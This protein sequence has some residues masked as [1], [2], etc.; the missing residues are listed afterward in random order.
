MQHRVEKT[1]ADGPSSASRLGARRR[2]GRGSKVTVPLPLASGQAV[3][4]RGPRPRELLIELRAPAHRVLW[5]QP[6]EPPLPRVDLSRV[7][8]ALEGDR[9][10]VRWKQAG[11][12]TVLAVSLPPLRTA[13]SPAAPAPVALRRIGCNP[14]LAPRATHDWEALAVFNAAALDIEGEVHLIYRAIGRSGRSV[15]GHAASRDGRQFH[16]RSEHPVYCDDGHA[17]CEEGEGAAPR[18]GEATYRSGASHVGCEDPRLSRLGDRVYMTYTRFDGRQPPGVAMTSIPVSDFAARRWNWSPPVM[19]SAPAEA[20]KNWVLF[21]EPVAGR[22]AL[23]HGISPG[24]MLAARAS[25][26]FEDGEFIESHYAP[27]GRPGSW[28]SRVRGAGPPPIR[29]DAGWLLLYHAM[30]RADPDRYKLGAMLL[31]LH[32]PTRVL[33][34]L[35]HPLLAPDAEYENAGLKWGVVY[36][37]GAV[38]IDGE[39]HVYYGGADTVVCVASIS[40]KVLLQQLLPAPALDDPSNPRRR[41]AP[42]SARRAQPLADAPAGRVVGND[43]GLQSL[44]GSPRRR[45]G[46]ALPGRVGR[47]R[48]GG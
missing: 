20:H 22:F 33:G 15:F 14:I 8:L 6:L 25:M 3:L 16:E 26:T 24:I 4:R 21:P 45:L 43:G 13:R 5:R 42:A 19:L 35:S 28:D 48:G 38:V 18:L 36:A 9:L 39:L 34:R 47:A 17:P 46:H 37:C 10:L 27:T 31:D 40:L 11:R 41:H 32:D 30:D 44:R 2:P 29:T 7:R 12:W 1:G 23:L